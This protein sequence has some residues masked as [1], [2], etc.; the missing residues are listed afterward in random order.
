VNG[1]IGSDTLSNAANTR[2]LAAAVPVIAPPGTKAYYR[3]VGITLT[4]GPGNVVFYTTDG[5]S[6]NRTS[7]FVQSGQYVVVN[8]NSTIQAMAAPSATVVSQLLLSHALSCYA[9]ST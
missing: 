2:N 4:A 7:A 9:W 3:P 6:P 5:S 1:Q 8:A